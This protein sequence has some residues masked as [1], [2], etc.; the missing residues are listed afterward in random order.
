MSFS[1]EHFYFNLCDFPFEIVRIMRGSFGLDIFN[2]HFNFGN[3]FAQPYVLKNFSKIGLIDTKNTVETFHVTFGINL[4]SS[5]MHMIEV[6]K[7]SVAET[8]NEEH[9]DHPKE[10]SDNEAVSYQKQNSQT[11]TRLGET[12][13]PDSSFRMNNLFL[14]TRLETGHEPIT[15]MKSLDSNGGG[16][17][18]NIVDETIDP[19]FES[20]ERFRF[21]FNL[22]CG[23]VISDFQ[24]M[25]LTSTS[26]YE[27]DHIKVHSLDFHQLAQR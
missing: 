26:P 11:T 12:R 1:F 9:P 7:A 24:V 19:K 21:Q 8:P 14:N 18:S 3:S 10:T 13:A 23:A 15:H 25:L 4:L 20:I 2:F 16:G 27:K 17:Q 5:L 6:L 22:I